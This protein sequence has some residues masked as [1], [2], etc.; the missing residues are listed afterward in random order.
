[1]GGEQSDPGGWG[2][3]DIE[4]VKTVAEVDPYKR[5]HDLLQRFVRLEISGAA[6]KRR[7]RMN[8]CREN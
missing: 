7:D 1:M 6:K 4:Y 5:T 3:C 2:G 8:A